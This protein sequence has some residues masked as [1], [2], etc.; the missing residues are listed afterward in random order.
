MRTKVQNDMYIAPGAVGLA[1]PVLV[2]WKLGL[3]C[4]V[5]S[6]SSYSEQGPLFDGVLGL[7]I[8]V[9]SPFVEDRL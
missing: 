4:Y 8:V 5:Q 1:A 7:L 6:F 3:C 9:A 2:F